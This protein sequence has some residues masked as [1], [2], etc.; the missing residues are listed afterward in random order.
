M[1]R[2]RRLPINVKDNVSCDVAIDEMIAI[3]FSRLREQ[4]EIFAEAQ[5]I[6]LKEMHISDNSIRGKFTDGSG[7]EFDINLTPHGNQ[8]KFEGSFS[9]EM[10]RISDAHKVG[11]SVQH[12][13]DALFHG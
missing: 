11:F 8:S 12:F 3:P 2:R 9:R 1:A 13:T 6:D 7:V 4:F 10:E 5:G